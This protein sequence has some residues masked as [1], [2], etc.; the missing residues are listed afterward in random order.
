MRIPR[1]AAAAAAFAVGLSAAAAHQAGEVHGPAD[2]YVYPLA[3][4]GEY[5]LPVIRPAADARLQDET[6][7]AAS[8]S[9]LFAG[10]VTV[11]AFMYTRCGD[12]CPL[13]AGRMA[14]LQ[15]LAAGDAS[16]AG[17]LRLA[18]L[19]F[20]PAH[21][22]PAVMADYA[23]NLR[24]DDPAAPPWLFLTAPD[25]A[26]IGPVLAAYGQ[27]VA[28]KRDPDDP[29]GPL[30]H[31]LRVFLVDGEGRIRNIYSADF[32]DPRLVLNDVRTLLLAPTSPR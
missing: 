11:L 24:V 15:A 8:L 20:D 31:L 27:P 9:A 19:S 29:T 4:P 26:A 7:A 18:S 13:A 3:A 14:D 10:R 12:V 22:R 21:D 6:G 16:V 25:E 32:L 28:R 2:A 17:V 5:A 23:R 1:P 30:S